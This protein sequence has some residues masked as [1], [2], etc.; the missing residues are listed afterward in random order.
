MGSS[1]G[2]T[3]WIEKV[4]TRESIPDMIGG[5]RGMVQV[6][7]VWLVRCDLGLAPSRTRPEV[8]GVRCL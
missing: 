5:Q 2:G 4:R 6:L 7:P 3:E 8:P 1:L